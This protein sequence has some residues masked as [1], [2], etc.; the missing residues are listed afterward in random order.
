MTRLLAYAFWIGLGIGFGS[1]V[2]MLAEQFTPAGTWLHD[3]ASTMLTMRWIGAVAGFIHIE[4]LSG[5]RSFGGLF[6][7]MLDEGSEQT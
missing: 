7:R 6:E 1:M 4:R 3:G 2:G 5:R